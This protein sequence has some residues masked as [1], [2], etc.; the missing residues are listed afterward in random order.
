M[1]GAFDQISGA[2]ANAVQYVF[3]WFTGLASWVGEKAQGGPALR[4]RR[5]G[6]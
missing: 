1:Q 4:P 5:P 6:G 2:A 3:D